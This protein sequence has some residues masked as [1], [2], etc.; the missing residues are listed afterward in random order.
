MNMH[1]LSRNGNARVG[2]VAFSSVVVNI[3][4]SEGKLIVFH[5]ILSVEYYS[6]K[7][8]IIHVLCSKTSHHVFSN[9]CTVI[10]YSYIQTW[11]S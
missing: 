10:K 3:V 1:V 4:Q 11:K 7:L 2:K 9:I 6:G 5:K 8:K